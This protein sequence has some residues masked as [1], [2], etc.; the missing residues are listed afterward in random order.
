MKLKTSLFA[1][2]YYLILVISSGA[3]IGAMTSW[4]LPLAAESYLLLLP[5]QLFALLYVGRWIQNKNHRA[6]LIR[7]NS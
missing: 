3:W 6:R 1:K 7:P 2:K 5:I 4:E